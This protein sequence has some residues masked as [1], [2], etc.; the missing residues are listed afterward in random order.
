[1]I[2]YQKGASLKAMNEKTV[3]FD[4]ARFTVITENLIRFEYADNRI[5]CDDTTLFA[6]NR[7][8]NGCDVEIIQDE[9]TLEIKTDVIL[10]FYKND[11]KSF[12]AENLYGTL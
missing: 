1:L 11:G 6:I 2:K 12:S 5:F 4:K 3:I 9:N 10:L 8:H 7:A